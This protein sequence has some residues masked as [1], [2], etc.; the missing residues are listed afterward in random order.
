MMIPLWFTGGMGLG[1]D[2]AVIPSCPLCGESLGYIMVTENYNKP[3]PGTPVVPVVCESCYGKHLKKGV[4]IISGEP[5]KIT[6]TRM[7]VLKED[8]FKKLFPKNEV[9]NER[10]SFMDPDEFTKLFGKFTSMKPPKLGSAKPKSLKELMAD[11][12]KL[13]VASTKTSKEMDKTLKELGLEEQA[14]HLRKLE[15]DTRKK[16][17][18]LN[19]SLKEFK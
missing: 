16:I 7:V 5:G 8:A 6:D 3:F 17:K 10:V 15:A 4:L 1:E 12:K 9:E 14:A 19:K 2:I 13:D 11:I 18:E